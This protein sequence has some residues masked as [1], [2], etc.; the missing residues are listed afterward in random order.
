M[1]AQ[2]GARANLPDAVVVPT[3]VE[4][5]LPVTLTIPLNALATDYTFAFAATTG[6]GGND[7]APATLTVEPPHVTLEITPEFIETQYD[8]TITYTI[9]LTNQQPSS[10]IY[11]PEGAT[12]RLDVEGL[13][14]TLPALASDIMVKSGQTISTTV[15]FTAD[16]SQGFY[17]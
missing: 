10:D 17:P 7:Y 14:I 8:E 2:C 13:P 11:Y 15:S 1:G 9:A 4:V 6:S 16:A 12:Y 5:M 3:G